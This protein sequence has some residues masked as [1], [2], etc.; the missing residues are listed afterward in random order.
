MDLTHSFPR[1]PLDRLQGIDHLKRMID[2]AK[3]H[4]AGKQGEYHYNCALDQLLLSHI[5]ISA[6]DFSGMVR[7]Y[8]TDDKIADALL[9]LF[10][11]AFAPPA[12]AR[13]NAGYEA[14]GPDTPEKKAYFKSLLDGIDPTRTDISTW[15]RLLDLEEGRPVPKSG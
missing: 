6:D 3:A 12:T 9:R 15:A 8:G 10:P 1:S 14:A 7:Q 4:N 2:K 13:F 11:A 5:G